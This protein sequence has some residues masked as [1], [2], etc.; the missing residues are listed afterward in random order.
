[1]FSSEHVFNLET[2]DGSN[3]SGIFESDTDTIQPVQ[4]Q[5]YVAYC[6]SIGASTGSACDAQHADSCMESAFIR[7]YIQPTCV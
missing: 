2:F 3:I 4:L 6:N 1:M 5:C 7:A